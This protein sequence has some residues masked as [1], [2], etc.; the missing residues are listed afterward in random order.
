MTPFTKCKGRERAKQCERG[1]PG[2][3]EYHLI[4]AQSPVVPA[5]SPVMPAQSP[6]MP[7]DAGIQGHQNNRSLSNDLNGVLCFSL[8]TRVRGYD[9]RRRA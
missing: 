8:D 2:R 9:G 5:Q 6:V 7:A 3:R 4:P 1:M